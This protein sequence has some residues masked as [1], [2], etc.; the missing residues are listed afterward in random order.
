MAPTLVQHDWPL[1]FE[2]IYDASDHAIGAC[3]GKIKDKKLD[4]FYYASKTLTGIQRNYT[5]TE[6]EL[7]SNVF[8][9]DKFQPYL[10][11]TKVTVY[12]NLLAIKYLL[13]KKK[14]KSMLI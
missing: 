6:K 8:I 2:L 1:S 5:T 11:G 9:F 4:V 7:L 12:T 14:G 13:L 3:L 10:I